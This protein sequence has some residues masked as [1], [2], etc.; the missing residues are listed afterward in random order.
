MAVVSTNDK[1]TNALSKYNKGLKQKLNSEFQ[2]KVSGKDL[3]SNDFTD[4]LKE[5]LENLEEISTD[6]FVT[7]SEL[8]NKLATVSG[9]S[10]GGGFTFAVG[11]TQP[12][13]ASM[14]LDTSDFVSIQGSTATKT[15]S[16]D[17]SQPPITVSST[18]PEGRNILWLNTSTES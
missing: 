15:F 6:T 4:E 11:D 2:K 12:V 7:Q 10:S 16:F 18:K 13:K 8:D 14:W 5:K 1:I 3:S 17:S 9:G